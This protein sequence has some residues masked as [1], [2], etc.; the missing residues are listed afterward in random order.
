MARTVTKDPVPH[1]ILFSRL[2]LTV[3]WS[4]VLLPF[5]Q[6][7]LLPLL[8]TDGYVMSQQ[9]IALGAAGV[10]VGGEIAR[11]GASVLSMN[12]DKLSLALESSSPESLVAEFDLVEEM[13][14]RGVGFSS[15]Q[16]AQFYEL[17][18]QAIVNLDR[19]A[20]DLMR[21][22]NLSSEVSDPL[23]EAFGVGSLRD[24]TLRL[25]STEGTA[26]GPDWREFQIEP[27]FR[28]QGGLRVNVVYRSKERAPVVAFASSVE[29]RVSRAV[30]MLKRFN[31]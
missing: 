16:H 21:S 27:S 17:I 28:S 23:S 29:E 9:L 22:L 10:E 20:I 30:G 18:A 24:V 13:L 6:V 19:S 1:E 26:L 2:H 3:R 31:A 25:V 8:E 7:R 12:L 4:T 14:W 11:K 15:S 5:E